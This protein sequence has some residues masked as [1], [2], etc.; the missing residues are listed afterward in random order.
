MTLYVRNT[1]TDLLSLLAAKL[2][3][4]FHPFIE[5][6]QFL[7]LSLFYWHYDLFLGRAYPIVLRDYFWLRA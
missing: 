5:K 4:E 7:N 2:A 3:F 1:V 6:P